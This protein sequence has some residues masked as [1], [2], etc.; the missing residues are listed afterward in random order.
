[1]LMKFTDLWTLRPLPQPGAVV[2]GDCYRIT[3]LTSRLLRLEYDRQQRFCD[4]ATQMAICREF[5]LPAFEVRQD[6]A[7]LTLE[8][9]AVRLE[10]DGQPFSSEG[11]SVTLKGAYSAYTSVWHYGDAPDT[12]GGTARTLDDAPGEIPLE[13]GLM[14]T[15]GYAVLDDSRSMR[16]DEAGNL[17]PAQA[18]GIDLYLFCYGHDYRACLRDYY[19]L[20]GH[21][22][23][24]PRYALGN[25]WSR[26]YPYTEQSYMQLMERF[27]KERVPLSVAVL[28]MNWHTTRIGPKYGAPWTGYTWDQT[29]FPNPERM[30]S[31]LHAHG[32]RVTLNDHPA[33]GVRACETLYPAMAQAMGMDPQGE[34][35]IPYDAASPRFQQAFEQVVLEDFRRKGVDFWWIDWQQKGGSSKPGMDPLFTLNHTRYLYALRQDQAAMTFSRYGGPGSHRYPIGFSGDTHIT[36]DALAFQPYFTATAAN[37]GYGWWS[38][39]IGGHMM[40]YKNDELA[41][42]WLQ[43]GVF[44]PIMRLHSTCC[45]F[46]G[47]EPWRYRKEVEL[48]MDKFLRLRHQMIPYLHT[49]NRRASEEGIPL[50]QPLYYQNPGKWDAFR[51]KNE[52][53]FGSDILVNPITQPIST[54]T[55]MGKVMALLPEGTWIDLFTGTV[56]N[57]DR[58]IELYRSLDSI[59]VLAKAGAIV[60]LDARTTGNAIDNPEILKVIVAAGADGS[61]RLDEEA[62][63]NVWCSTTFTYKWG[64]EA[65]LTITPEKTK[66]EGMPAERAYELVFTGTAQGMTAQKKKAD[67]TY[68][69]LETSYDSDKQCTTVIL[70]MQDIESEITVVTYNTAPAD[71]HQVERIFELLNRA[72]I[73]FSLKDQIYA[74]AQKKGSRNDAYLLDQLTLLNAPE[75]VFGAVKEILTALD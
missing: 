41:L 65:V 9:E 36:W 37:I 61:F 31:W 45:E 49:M 12:L 71:N 14:S 43:L 46:N 47:K 17:L 2:M 44:S 22:P 6:G 75:D 20:S 68:E 60:T 48:I 50:I 24:L 57:G 74:I 55:R 39:D 21:T 54:A 30:L 3:V 7:R 10:Y 23:V 13:D 8:T 26:F 52:Y 72:E 58:K 15:K 32:L 51:M 19:Q 73:E 63:D 59:P 42:R 16:M 34:A 27:A 11:L 33:D 62:T 70:P 1:M 5:P 4:S 64:D 53:Y 69:T 29:C 38:H 56:Y 35:P 25:W 67:G 66:K 18:H 40:G 28:D